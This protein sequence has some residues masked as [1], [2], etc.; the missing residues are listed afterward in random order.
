MLQA[1]VSKQEAPQSRAEPSDLHVTFL[2]IVVVTI[3]E[4]VGS[5]RP[6]GREIPVREERDVEPLGPREM[7][8]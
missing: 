6:G 3:V 5:F 8:Y 2:V 4:F 7:S 1:S